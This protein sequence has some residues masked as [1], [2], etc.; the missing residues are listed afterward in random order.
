MWTSSRW[1]ARCSWN[2]SKVKLEYVD[3]ASGRRG[4]AD[5]MQKFVRGTNQPLLFL[6]KR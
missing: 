2:R 4:V 6:M 5:G 3:G 1:D